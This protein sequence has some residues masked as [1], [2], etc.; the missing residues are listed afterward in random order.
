MDK[1]KLKKRVYRIGIIGTSK[2]GK[3]TFITTCFDSRFRK[4]LAEIIKKNK[5]GQ[6]KVKVNYRISSD[7]EYDENIVASIVGIQLKPYPE[8]VYRTC[9]EDVQTEKKENNEL[10]YLK[11]GIKKEVKGLLTSLGLVI[12]EN[13]LISLEVYN[14]LTEDSNQIINKLLEMNKDVEKVYKV[15]N[16]EAGAT[17]IESIT[18]ESKA[19]ETMRDICKKF[20]IPCLEFSDTRGVNDTN[21]QDLLDLEEVA[22]E[23]NDD[24]TV[25]D[26]GN[27]VKKES[28]M[29]TITAIE[30]KFGL[31]DVD[32]CLCM[33]SE[34]ALTG[35]PAK[36]FIQL[37]QRVA[38][39]IPV[40]IIQKSEKLA[41]DAE[42]NKCNFSNS[43]DYE[44]YTNSKRILRRH[45]RIINT[46]LLQQTM[47]SESY[48]ARVIKQNSSQ[49]LLPEVICNEKESPCDNEM[50]VNAHKYVLN[51]ILTSLNQLVKARNDGKT[52]WNENKNEIKKGLLANAKNVALRYKNNPFYRIY[53]N[54]KR[55]AYSSD[56][57]LALK[58]IHYR[59]VW[60]QGVRGGVTPFHIYYTIARVSM[61]STNFIEEIIRN[62]LSDDFNVGLD[63]NQ[64]MGVYNY[65]YDM[66]Y[67]DTYVSAKFHQYFHS[68]YPRSTDRW[69]IVEKVEKNQY[70]T[71]QYLVEVLSDFLGM[72]G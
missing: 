45:F 60:I 33:Y 16:S 51:K 26:Q 62:I 55:K 72:I 53:P 49:I 59:R 21:G 2:A 42:E 65:L 46:E 36:I 34:E 32:I 61:L 54:L 27:V 44:E 39:R 67:N 10:L 66:L 35:S 14:K 43:I 63:G 41:D 19:S 22:D 4:N 23:E 13:Q 18:I 8:I 5:L 29:N 3:S 50:Y 57:D 70:S 17:I 37:L 15:L 9:E 25:D 58:E 71:Q 7:Y 20:E 56:I 69:Y 30:S 68:I 28:D 47:V 6:T 52:I 12:N 1:N 64:K 24:E 31:Q 38:T 11:K 48:M 40:I